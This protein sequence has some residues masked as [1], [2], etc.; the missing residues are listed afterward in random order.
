[1]SYEQD[2]ATGKQTAGRRIEAKAKDVQVVTMRMTLQVFDGEESLVCWKNFFSLLPM[3]FFFLSLVGSRCSDCGRCSIESLLRSLKE[4]DE[5]PISLD[6]LAILERLRRRDS[7]SL[8]SED[9]DDV[10]SQNRRG[11]GSGKAFCIALV[12]VDLDEVRDG[13]SV[14]MRTSG[15]GSPKRGEGITG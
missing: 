8:G 5:V 11:L 14:E 4:D 12:I 9:K 6:R 10:R 13:T 3:F 7:I 15:P 2:T 1:M